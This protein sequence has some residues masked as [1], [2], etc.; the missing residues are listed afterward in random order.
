MGDIVGD[1]PD[2]VVDIIISEFCH[3]GSFKT[4]INFNVVVVNITVVLVTKI[5]RDVCWCKCVGI[6]CMNQFNYKRWS[7]V[8]NN[9]DK[10]Q[11]NHCC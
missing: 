8:G 4:I 9:Q 5:M 1:F 11:G 6:N 2:M 3:E 7:L 10:N